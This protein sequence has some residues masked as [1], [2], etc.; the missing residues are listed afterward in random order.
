[1]IF[2]FFFFQFPHTVIL[3][4]L[5][6]VHAWGKKKYDNVQIN[7]ITTMYIQWCGSVRVKTMYN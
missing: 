3:L 1:M 7:V 5:C 2:F 4:R 6:A